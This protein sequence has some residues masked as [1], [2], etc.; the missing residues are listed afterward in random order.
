MPH[1]PAAPLLLTPGGV[2]AL[3]EQRS[4]RI[5]PVMQVLE[6]RTYDQPTARTVVPVACMNNNHMIIN[7]IRMFKLIESI[8]VVVMS[9]LSDD[10]NNVVG[11]YYYC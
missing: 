6:I 3:F 7:M 8:S 10:R 9:L 4:S 11:P 5:Q 2:V 1:G